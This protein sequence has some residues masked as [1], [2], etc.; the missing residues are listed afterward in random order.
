[1]NTRE[2]K[3]TVGE[4]FFSK[5]P[6]GEEWKGTLENKE[7]VE[8]AIRYSRNYLDFINKEDSFIGPN[9][10]D[11][12]NQVLL[13]W[14]KLV[15]HMK[16]AT[17]ICSNEFGNNKSPEQCRLLMQNSITIRILHVYIEELCFF[18]K[19]YFLNYYY[20]QTNEFN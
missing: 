9:Q 13:K 16:E 3:M 17:F 2:N 19:G 15:S 20:N 11:F 7:S 6:L 14:P 10:S 8:Q 5:E 12:C 1:M 18:K 4:W